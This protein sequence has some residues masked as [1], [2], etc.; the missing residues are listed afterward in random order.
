MHKHVTVL[1]AL[2]KNGFAIAIADGTYQHTQPPHHLHQPTISITHQPIPLLGHELSHYRRDL[3]DGVVNADYLCLREVI[4]ITHQPIPHLSR[5]FLLLGN[6]LSHYRRDLVYGVVVNA[7]CLC[8]KEVRMV[9]LK[10]RF[11]L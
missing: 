3:V 6:E 10:R 8:T 2:F 1:S 4:S 9:T 5:H 7:D 11:G